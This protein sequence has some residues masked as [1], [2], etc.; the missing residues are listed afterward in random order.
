[1]GPDAT[2]RMATLALLLNPARAWASGMPDPTKAAMTAASAATPLHQRRQCALENAAH[3]SAR[4]CLVARVYE[5]KTSQH[6]RSSLAARGRFFCP[7]LWLRLASLLNV[8]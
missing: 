6:S 4:V 3:V 5:S 7:R 2:V 1:M 8:R